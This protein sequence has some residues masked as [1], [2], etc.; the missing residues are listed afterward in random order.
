MRPNLHSP[1]RAIWVLDSG[2]TSHMT[3]NPGLYTE[4]QEKTGYVRIGDSSRIKVEG[5]GDVK[6]GCT[7]SSGYVVT[8]RDCLY[9]LELGDGSLVSIRKCQK[10]GFYIVGHCDTLEVTTPDG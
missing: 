6:L 4:L 8:L 9:V 10:N 5:I 7:S 2:A 3:S 1:K